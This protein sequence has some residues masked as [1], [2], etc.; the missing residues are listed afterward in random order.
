MLREPRKRFEQSVWDMDRAV[1]GYMQMTVCARVHRS[2]TQARQ[3]RDWVGVH[4]SKQ[5]RRRREA[6][7]RGPRWLQ[8][9]SNTLLS[10]R[11]QLS[12][13]SPLTLPTKRNISSHFEPTL[14]NQLRR[15]ACAVQ[16][17]AQR[18]AERIAINV[19]RSRLPHF[20]I[21]QVA[22]RIMILPEDLLVL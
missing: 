3:L 16:T 13:T 10:Q 7:R 22:Q 8:R 2:A 14:S 9:W 15:R 20:I 11:F 17:S 12:E 18:A 1:Q 19:E 5:Q 21:P 6:R 4:A